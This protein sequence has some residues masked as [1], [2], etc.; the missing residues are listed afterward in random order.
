MQSILNIHSQELGDIVTAKNSRHFL[1]YDKGGDVWD[2][3]NVED[4]A[5]NGNL[6]RYNLKKTIQRHESIIKSLRLMALIKSVLDSMQCQMQVQQFSNA[7]Y[8]LKI[9]L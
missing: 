5:M 3:S 8:F 6:E 4:E 7:Y 2:V 9:I 1:R